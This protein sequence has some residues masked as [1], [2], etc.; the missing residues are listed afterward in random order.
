MNVNKIF[1]RIL[2]FSLFVSVTWAHVHQDFLNDLKLFKANSLLPR[3]Q[4]AKLQAAEDEM[5]SKRLFWTPDLAISAGQQRSTLNQSS[6]SGTTTTTDDKRYLQASASLNIFKSGQDLM[7]LERAQA[8]RKARVSAA[9]DED[10][11]LE[12]EAAGLIFKAV[13][14]KQTLRIQEELRQTK[15]DST[16]IVKDRFAQ[17]KAPLQEVT[18][19]QV[20]LNQQI[21][22]IRTAK[23]SVS[24]N[25]TE[26]RNLFVRSVLTSDWP[27]TERSELCRSLEQS[28]EYSVDHSTKHGEFP[29]FPKLESIFWNSRANELEWRTARMGHGPRLDF[30]VEV[31]QYPIPERGNQQVVSVL[32]LKIPIWSRLETSAAVSASLSNF[33][34]A[35]ADYLSLKQ[36]V[37][38]QNEF[39]N[40]KLILARENLVDAKSNL[41][42]SK[43]LYQDFLKSFS[44]GRIS[45][46]DLFLEQNRLLDSESDLALSQLVYH[47]TLMESCYF[48]GLSISR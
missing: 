13:F 31:Q 22:R 16:K 44:L 10:L 7:D 8:L 47:Q 19:V 27:L 29:S 25:E 1:L 5:L 20:D 18:K 12:L 38:G 30:S 36:K 48:R 32:E 46:N 33:L 17:G 23:I 11:K 15:E 24:E 4:K 42:S 3:T 34:S 9:Q 6:N 39:L 41:A 43:R 21:N 40:K 37:E 45:I 35:E 2:A 26:M 28:S 14:L